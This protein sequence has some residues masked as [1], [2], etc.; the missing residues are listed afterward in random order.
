MSR[1]RAVWP[2]RVFSAISAGSVAAAMLLVWQSIASYRTEMAAVAPVAASVTREPPRVA[3]SDGGAPS[4]ATPR[5][6]AKPENHEDRSKPA[7]RRPGP[8]FKHFAPLSD[9]GY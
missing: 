5:S 3:R 4:E 1:V 2:L 6:E 7:T 9:P 8:S